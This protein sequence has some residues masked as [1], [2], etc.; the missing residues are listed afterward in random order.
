MTVSIQ[1]ILTGLPPAF[2]PSTP[3]GNLLLSQVN[4]SHVIP[5]A[6]ENR[7]AFKLCKALR[8]LDP[9][10]FITDGVAK[11]WIS[12]NLGDLKPIF[13]AGK[14]EL[15]YGSRIRE[16]YSSA[17]A[18]AE[19]LMAWLSQQHQVHRY[20]LSETFPNLDTN[21]GPHGPTKLS[22]N[23][24]MV[25]FHKTHSHASHRVAHNIDC[26]KTATLNNADEKHSHLF[27]HP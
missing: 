26:L 8:N 11:Q 18:T 15:E 17:A 24:C 23:C 27:V 19:E 16:H 20:S 6:Q 7:S 22:S 9:P 1:C 4:R 25:I 12:H 10:I 14:L 21:A 3:L 5:A 13:N 2:H